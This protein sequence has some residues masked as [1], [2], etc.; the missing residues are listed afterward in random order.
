MSV[1]HY[2]NF[3]VAS[4]LMP[5]RLRRPVA[6]IYHFARA[7]DDI[8]DE[9]DLGD[10]ERLRQLDEFRAELDRIG[11]GEKPRSELFFALFH[12]IIAYGLPLQPF[13][14]LLD[15]FSQDVVQKRYADFD[16]LLD[17]CR[18]SANPVGNLLLHLYDEA[19]PV[20]LAYSDAICTALQLINFWQDVAKDWAIGRVYLPQDDLARFGVS[21]A[22]IGAG[23]ADDNWR[24]L[25]R[26]EVQR[27]R[28]MM[29]EGRPLGI[30]LTGRIGLEMRM[31]IQGG[32]RI[33]DKIEAAD[34]DVFNRRPVLRPFDWFI[35]LAKSAP[36]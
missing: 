30:I 13:Y 2:E 27:A 17:Y 10:A 26:F 23:R 12:Q 25:M 7:A 21:E 1:D 33:L 19:T 15:A 20:N 34:Y 6:A 16:E 4:I 18:R 22:Q 11:Q 32:L 9:G 3:P 28:A 29:L 14:D 8:A 35:M 31:I 5:R 36:F 24:A